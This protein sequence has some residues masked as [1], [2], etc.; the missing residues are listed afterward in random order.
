M[1]K[2]FKILYVDKFCFVPELTKLFQN[3]LVFSE[4]TKVEQDKQVWN[5]M[6]DFRS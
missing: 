2:A 4:A 5:N 3:S 6:N 1:L